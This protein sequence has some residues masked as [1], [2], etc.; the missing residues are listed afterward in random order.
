M[1]RFINLSSFQSPKITD[2]CLSVLSFHFVSSYQL[3]IFP[4]TFWILEGVVRS[5]YF[6]KELELRFSFIGYRGYNQTHDET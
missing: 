6:N 3:Q 2:S 1:S 4:L 5:V